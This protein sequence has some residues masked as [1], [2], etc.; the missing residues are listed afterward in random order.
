MDELAAVCG[1]GHVRPATPVDVVGGVPARWVAAPSDAEEVSGLLRVAAAHDLAVVVTGSG[2]KLDWGGPPSH[3]DILV[4]T[5]RLSGFHVT[6]SNAT[7]GAGTPLRAV[8]AGLGRSGLRLT[9]DVGSPGATLGGV[10]ATNEAGPLRLTYGTPR[11]QVVSMRFVRADGSTAEA[12]SGAPKDPMGYDLSKLLCGS[13]GTLGVI[14]E[15][16]LRLHPV[17]EARAWI[18]RSVRSPLEVSELTTALLRSALEP[19]AIE[20]DLPAALYRPGPLGELSVLVEGTPGFVA[21]RGQAI[22][23][24]LANGATAQETPPDWWGRYPFSPDDLALQV[25]APVTD[26]HAAL[27]AL[28]DATGAPVP[29]RGSIGSG[30]VHVGL[31]SR[32]GADRLGAVMTAVRT[33]LMSRGGRCEMLRG[34][35]RL[36]ALMLG[37][38]PTLELPMMRQLKERFDP[39]RR[40]SPGRLPGGR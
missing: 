35:Q 29:V 40:L 14:T 11:D 4:D 37:G 21:D 1:E 20:V 31:S 5:D 36:R 23:R 16:T 3:V 13:Y 8:R 38:G 28:R 9:L 34:P 26:M 32:I 30:S 24:L 10:L 17:P 7:I 33:T 15:A 12:G 27:Y 19:A 6:D 2:S 39:D 25:D 18:V 22:A